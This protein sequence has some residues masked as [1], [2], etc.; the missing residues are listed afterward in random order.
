MKDRDLDELDPG[1]AQRAKRRD[2]K[3]FTRMVVDGAGIRRQAQ[4]LRLRAL[5]RRDSSPS[6]ST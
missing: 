2:R 4:A 3:R 5:R 1:E 6:R